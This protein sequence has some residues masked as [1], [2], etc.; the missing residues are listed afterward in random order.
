MNNIFRLIGVIAIAAIIGF[1]FVSCDGDGDGDGNTNNTDPKALV[2]TLTDTQKTEGAG[3]F[4]I[5]IL[6][7]GTTTLNPSSII[8][9][10]G[11]NTNTISGNTLTVPLYKTTGN[12][13]WSDSGTYDVYLYCLEDSANTNNTA[14]KKASVAFTSATTTVAGSTFTKQ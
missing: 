6:P 5:Y 13:R 2:V 9:G 7:A 11:S 12:T 3:G 10:N 8:A 1:S 4:T 14:Y